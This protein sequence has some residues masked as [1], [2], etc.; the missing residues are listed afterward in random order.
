VCSSDLF[1]FAYHNHD[2]E[3]AET[4]DGECGMDILLKNTDPHLVGIQLHIG[5]LARFGIDQAEYV[6]KLGRRLKVL[7]V[8]TFQREGE[9]FDSSAAINAAK[10]FDVE[11]AIVENMFGAPTDVGAVK[12]SVGTIRDAVRG[13]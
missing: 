7:H 12:R 10:E 4:F 6:K 13:L 2:F 9:P 5:Q 1:D 11:W 8:H 3:Y